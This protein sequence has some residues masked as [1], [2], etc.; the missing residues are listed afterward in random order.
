MR[1]E[2]ILRH[3]TARVLGLVPT[4]L[5]LITIAFFLI[6][7]AP[8]GPFDSE[9]ILPP[10][11]LA[12]LERNALDEVGG[13]R[14]ALKDGLSASPSPQL[15]LF[16]AREGLLTSELRRIDVARMTPLEA[17]NALDR[18]RRLAGVEEDDG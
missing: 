9:K 18:L 13:P 1:R 5:V 15:D 14:F 12:N 10:E 8:G 2:G 6:R 17:M 3:A 4:M 16:G 11:I 7:V